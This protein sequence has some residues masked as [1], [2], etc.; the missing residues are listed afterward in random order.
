MERDRFYSVAPNSINITER[1][2]ETR[3]LEN[4]LEEFRLAEET[5]QA[6]SIAYTPQEREQ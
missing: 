3:E 1:T 6:L 5:A 2:P 4:A